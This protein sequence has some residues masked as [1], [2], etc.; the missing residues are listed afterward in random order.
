MQGYNKVILIGNL[1]RDPDVRVTPAGLKIAK[2]SLAVNRRY[3]TSDGEVKEEVVFVDCD[4]FGKGAEVVEKY[5]EKG[6]ALMVE[7]RLK[8]DQWETKDGQ[9][10]SK[11]CVVVESMTFV[12]GNDGEKRAEEPQGSTHRPP[13][14]PGGR[15]SP[16]PAEYDSEDDIPF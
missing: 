6:K 1:T 5:C 2:Y 4:Q 16:P 3:K 11:L 10:R 15:G 8:M 9:K 14:V 13:P 7:G 12:G